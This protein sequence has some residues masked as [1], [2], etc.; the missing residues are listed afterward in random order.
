MFLL[1]LAWGSMPPSL[2]GALSKKCL[3]WVLDFVGLGWPPQCCLL[4]NHLLVTIACTIWFGCL[5]SAYMINALFGMAVWL[6]HTYLMHYL[7]WLFG[8]SIYG[9]PLSSMLLI[10]MCLATHIWARWGIMGCLISGRHCDLGSVFQSSDCF[11]SCNL[12]AEHAQQKLAQPMG[13]GRLS[14]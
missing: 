5:A 2:V 8:F 12:I 10:S 3:G 11:M 14:K 7:V 1:M 4:I 6:Q 9:V 13:W